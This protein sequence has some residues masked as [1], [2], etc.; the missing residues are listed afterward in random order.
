MRLANEKDINVKISR[1]EMKFIPATEQ[2]IGIPGNDPKVSGH[3]KGVIGGTLGHR[4]ELVLGNDLQD[5][6]G[7][8]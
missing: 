5:S 8:G 7:R 6:G 2:A 4:L 3:W 1:K